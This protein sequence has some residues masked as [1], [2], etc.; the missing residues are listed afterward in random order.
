[1]KESGLDLPHERSKYGFPFTLTHFA[2]LYPQVILMEPLTPFPFENI[3]QTRLHSSRMR[4][5]RL[6]PISPS[7]HCAGRVPASGAGGGLLPGGV[8]TSGP[9]GVCSWG[10]PASGPGGGCIPACNGADA[11]CGQN[12]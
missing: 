8:P 6:L 2:R 3:L 1:M 11:P 10:V 5:V 7:M 12:S 9:E 4:T